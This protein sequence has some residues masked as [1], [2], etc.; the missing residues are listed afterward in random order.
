MTWLNYIQNEVSP[1][2]IICLFLSLGIPFTIYWVNRKYH[3]AVD[4]EWRKK[5]KEQE[6]QKSDKQSKA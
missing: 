6:R 2:G 1:L 4:P 3:D 5:R